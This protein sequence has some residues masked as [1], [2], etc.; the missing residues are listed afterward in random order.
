MG[1]VWRARHQLLARPCA[2]KLIRPTASEEIVVAAVGRFRLEA[3]RSS[4]L[5]SPNTVRLSDFGVSETG[6]LYFVM[7]LL[8]GLDLFTLIQRFGP[9]PAAR[10][11]PILRQACRSLAEARRR[12]RDIKPHNLFLVPLESDF[13]VVKVLR[14]GLVKSVGEDDANLT[15]DGVPD[16]HARLRAARARRREA[17]RRDLRPL[18][19]LAAW[20][21]MLTGSPVFSGD[22]MAMLI[23]HVP[24][25]APLRRAQGALI[26]CA[27]SSSSSS[28]ASPRSQRNR[29]ASALAL[30][31]RLAE[32]VQ[33]ADPWGQ[34]QA[35]Q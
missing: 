24:R 26:F 1:E 8:D 31:R 20:P 14:L 6:S 5:T 2:V 7:E 22:P 3:R 25:P 4:H 27:A 9:L 30:D 29:P 18:L 21:S 13:D 34:E 28:T 10:A 16:S 23:R 12:Y 35:E 33:R 15:A 19:L 11:V 32:A 17:R